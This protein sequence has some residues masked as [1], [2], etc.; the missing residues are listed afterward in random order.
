MQYTQ[1]KR[2]LSLTTPLGKDVLLL[3]AFTG[4]EE[5]SRLF[6]FQLDMLS[7]KESIAARD[8]VGKEVSWTVGRADKELRPFHGV[9]SRFSAGTMRGRILR[10]YRAEVVPWLWFLTRTADCRIFQNKT[11]PEI[12]EQIFKDLGFSAYKADLKGKYVKRDYCVQYRET[13]FAFV[14]RLMEQEGIF[15][16]FQHEKGKHTLIL[17]DSKNAYK[18]AVEKKVIFSTGATLPGH[19]TRWEHQYEFRPGKFAQTDYNFETPSTSLMTNTQTTVK[20]PGNDK[21]EVYDYPGD[22]LKKADGEALTKVHMEEEETAHDVVSADGTCATFGPGYKFTLDKHECSSEQGKEY[23]VTS[24]RHAARTTGYISG[25]KEGEDYRNIFACIPSAVPFRPTR[26]T[27]RPVVR[28]PQTAVVVGPR[29]EEIYTDKYGRAKVQFHWDREGK[30]DENASCW[31]RVAQ[32]WAGKNWGGVFLPRI[33]QEVIVDFLEGDPDRP[34]I[35]GR[36]YNA[37]LMPPY[38]LP[39]NMTQ[40]GVKSRASK[41]GAADN[42]NELRFE[43]KKGS[44]EIYFHA[45]KDFNRVVENNDTLKVGFDKK[46]KGD[47]TIQVFND[48]TLTIGNHRTT[49][50]E[51]GNDTLTVKKGNRTTTVEVG[52]DALTIQKGNQ[53][54]KIDAGSGSTEAMQFIELKVGANSI[55]ID[56]TG[57]TVKGINI[58]VMGQAQTLVKAPNTMVVGDALLVLKGGQLVLG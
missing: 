8:I 19:V 40:S 28:G 50:V 4:Q 48:Q 7:E 36:V 20:L 41:N 49:T 38:T 58:M 10:E 23:V 22:Y 6:S 27:P 16:Y 3:S 13:D 33:G 54:T 18:D 39:A 5:M 24:V 9:V 1:E 47:Q 56:Q 14:S 29:G 45:E 52:N 2:L 53:T 31:V 44:E 37:E 42:F 17:A 51:K 43:D 15:Y 34:I 25:D 21:F 55:R 12:V 11:A 35:T 30:K 26:T 46:D 57:I 32:N